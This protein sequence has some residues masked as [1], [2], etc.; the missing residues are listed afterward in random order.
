MRCKNCGKEIE[1][2]EIFCEDCK[3]RMKTT[4]SREELKE[5]ERLIEE[6]KNNEDLQITKELP[7]IENIE[8][9]IEEKTSIDVSE[10]YD[11][12][13]PEKIETREERNQDKNNKDQKKILIIIISIIAFLV[14]VVLVIVIMNI[15][16][17]KKKDTVEIDYNNVINEY[18]KEVV[19]TVKTYNQKEKKIPKWDNIK[20]DI[21]YTKYLV[22]CSTHEIYDDET[23]YLANCKVNE[24]KVNYTYGKEQKE[25]DKEKIQLTIYKKDNTFNTE[26]GE[27]IGTVTCSSNDDCKHFKTFNDYE[28]TTENDENYLYNY[29]NDTLVFGPFKLEETLNDENKL[30]GLLVKID[31]TTKLYSLVSNKLLKEVSGTLETGKTNENS[32][33]Y[34]YGYA[35]FALE[36]KY[37][38]VNLKTGNVSYFVDGI[39]I[40]ILSETSNL[41]YFIYTDMNN[42]YKV[43]NSNGK[44]LFDESYSTFK[45]ENDNFVFLDTDRFAIYDKNL[46]LKS[47]SKNYDKVLQIADTYIVVLNNKNLE[48]IDREGK[49]I[50]KFSDEFKSDY[51]LDI[52]NS[53][54]EK[55]KDGEY[56]YLKV[57]NKSIPENTLGYIRKYYYVKETGKS[58]VIEENK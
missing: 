21:K 45:I 11:Q 38:F 9:V 8:A 30:Y 28:I 54:I 35:L 6:N 16:S 15:N 22:V 24:E 27:K 57:I 5:L 36:N 14:I 19:N 13:N 56:L 33:L 23:I 12:E 32:V 4:S 3:E 53:G 18:G 52:K 2:Y 58:G 7:S 26:S 51:E 46:T 20:D 40:D 1:K 50:V 39:N 34:K 44:N 48:V 37:N 10:I 29:K 55:E 49:S 31:N 42:K 47:N 43:I 41:L 17:K 25:E